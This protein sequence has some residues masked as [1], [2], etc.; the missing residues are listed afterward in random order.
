MIYINLTKMLI[1]IIV[2]EDTCRIWGTTQK[3]IAYLERVLSVFLD[4]Q[5]ILRNL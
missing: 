5:V 3:A 2:G 4:P 1:E